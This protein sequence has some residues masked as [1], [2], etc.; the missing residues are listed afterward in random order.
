MIS[1]KT[2]VTGGPDDGGDGYPLPGSNGII[3]VTTPCP[4]TTFGH[5]GGIRIADAQ[6]GLV[7]HG[8]VEITT[9]T[10]LKILRANP[11]GL[12]AT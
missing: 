1:F 12:L 5:G 9:L 10:S 3:S 11:V 2:K 4:L 7:V 6:R 8:E